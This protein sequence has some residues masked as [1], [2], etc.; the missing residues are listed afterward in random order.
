MTKQINNKEWDAP[1][2]PELEVPLLVIIFEPLFLIGGILFGLL[3]VVYR[4]SINVGMKV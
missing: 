3:A 2:D 4:N 1:W